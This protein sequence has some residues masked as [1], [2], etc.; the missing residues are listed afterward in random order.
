MPCPYCDIISIKYRSYI[1]RVNALD[2]KGDYPAM[3]G[4][5]LRAEDIYK[6]NILHSFKCK[7]CQLTLTF[8]YAFHTK[9]CNIVYCSVQPD[10]PA[11][12][13]GSRL[14]FMGKLSICCPFTGHI[15][16]HLAACEKRRHFFKQLLPAV[17]YTDTHWCEH[18]VPRKDKK[19]DAKL[20]YIYCYM[21]N[22]LSAVAYYDST[23]FVANSGKLL[24]RVHPAEN[25]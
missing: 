25:I 24:Y 13:D 11:D 20:I 4:S 5:F 15:L 17:Q 23:V 6:R 1:V 14:E 3:L 18:L 19:I 10:C 21:R 8:F 7:R 9:L 16:Y 2:C 22:A 12:I